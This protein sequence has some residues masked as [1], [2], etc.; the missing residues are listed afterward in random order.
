VVRSPSPRFRERLAPSAEGLSASRRHLREWLVADLLL[1][2]GEPLDDILLVAGELGTN[3]VRAARTGVEL[4]AW[5]D[6]GEVTVEVTDD[7]PGFDG[8][9]PSGDVVPDPGR[10]R[11]RGLFIVQTLAKECRVQS[12]PYGT[13]VRAAIAV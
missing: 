5:V 6:G 8:M 9:L 3:A 4:R 2:P 10:E 11:G 1:P 12:G 13:L 7:G